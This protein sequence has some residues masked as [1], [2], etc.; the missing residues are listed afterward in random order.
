MLTH[1]PLYVYKNT[2]IRNKINSKYT[3]K[4]N[5]TGLELV[6]K[7]DGRRVISNSSNGALRK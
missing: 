7:H 6:N 4:L 3:A 5:F 1:L 2:V